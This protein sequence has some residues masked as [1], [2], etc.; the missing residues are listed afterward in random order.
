MLA[1]VMGGV[2][3]LAL[4]GILLLAVF[5]ARGKRI[6][7]EETGWVFLDLQG[8]QEFEGVFDD[9]GS[10]SEGLAAVRLGEV[11][12]FVNAKGTMVIEPA[13]SAVGPFSVDGLARAQ[14]PTS[15]MYGYL[16]KDGA[17]AL[18]PRFDRAGD[19]AEG[20]AWIGRATG[21]RT[22]RITSAEVHHSYGYIDPQGTWI[23]EPSDQGDP[24]ELTDARDF[25]QGRAAVRVQGLWGYIDSSGDP[26]VPPTYPEAGPFERGLAAVR[27]GAR[28]GYIDESG[29]LVIAA[30][31]GK[32]G[33]FGEGIALVQG[34]KAAFI[35]PNGR[36]HTDSTYEAA[37][38][39]SEGL[40]AVRVDGNWGF[41]DTQGVLA[42]SPA[43]SLVGAAGFREGRAA[44]ATM[45]RDGLI[46][47]PTWFFV[48]RN[49]VR[50]D[51][52]PVLQIRDLGYSEGKIAVRVQRAK[53]SK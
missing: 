21:L 34:A 44:V 14:D 53:E 37:N 40:A 39:Y 31:F 48:D 10:F 13:F 49:G 50:I 27:S 32:A 16:D 35:K 3:G 12:G 8:A 41:I 47:R 24:L 11:W 4:V 15:K 30:A 43:F 51:S 36:R 2:M 7:A 28:W 26:V 33:G 5:G 29:E 45:E 52:R 20:R 6:R 46:P 22:S 19:F 9:A 1:W 42:I 23:V 25:S 18:E 17:W 38:P